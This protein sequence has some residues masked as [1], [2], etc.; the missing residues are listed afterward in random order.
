[1]SDLFVDDTEWNLGP[2]GPVHA[3]TTD[4]DT[5]AGDDLLELAG[6]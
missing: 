1:M 2:L 3:L 6:F 5:A 4:I